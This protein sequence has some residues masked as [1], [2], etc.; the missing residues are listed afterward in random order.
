LTP[1]KT[2]RALQIG[3]K[4]ADRATVSVSAAVTGTAQQTGFG[5]SGAESSPCPFLTLAS[6]MMYLP[7][8]FHL[9]VETHLHRIIHGVPTKA[10]GLLSL[11][12]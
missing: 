6:L 8:R 4:A 10:L 11:F 2:S 12:V 5:A 1:L 7:L 9:R 3:N